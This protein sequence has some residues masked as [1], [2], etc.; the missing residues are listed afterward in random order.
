[1]SFP[2]NFEAAAIVTDKPAEGDTEH[3]QSP[4]ELHQEQHVVSTLCCT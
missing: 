4:R 3:P 2:T 1:M